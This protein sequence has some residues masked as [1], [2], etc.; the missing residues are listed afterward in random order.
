MSLP[1]L[2]TE[3]RGSELRRDQ[4]FHHESRSPIS[5][6]ISPTRI[7]I[8]AGGCAAPIASKRRLGP[9]L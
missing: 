5:G 3:W 1:I 9:P 7:P 8:E 2:L 6:A 4:L